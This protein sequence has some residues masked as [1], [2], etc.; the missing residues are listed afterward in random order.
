MK[1]RIISMLLVLCM[2]LSALPISASAAEAEPE[3][4]HSADCGHTNEAVSS[5]TSAGAEVDV[6]ERDRSE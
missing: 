5:E 3:H 2:L 1:K 6:A 4:V